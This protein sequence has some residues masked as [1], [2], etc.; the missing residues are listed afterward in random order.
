M[1]NR[2]WLQD[3]VKLTQ[4]RESKF[5]YNRVEYDLISAEKYVRIDNGNEIVNKR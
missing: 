5:G 4:K 3:I 2:K 1:P